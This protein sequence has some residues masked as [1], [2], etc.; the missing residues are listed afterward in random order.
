MT[1]VH[2]VPLVYRN[3]ATLSF[4]EYIRDTVLAIGA[5]KESVN[6]IFSSPQAIKELHGL[7]V[8]SDK[9]LIDKAKSLYAQ[10]FLPGP[11]LTEFWPVIQSKISNGMKW[12]NLPQKAIVQETANIKCLSLLTWVR[13]ALMEAA[14]IA[15]FG[16]RLLELRPDL[17]ETFTKFDN[18]SWKMNYQMPPAT[19]PEFYKNKAEIIAVLKQYFELSPSERQGQMWFVNSLEAQMRQLQMPLDDIACFFLMP[20]W[21]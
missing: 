19:C 6:K 15:V 20:V 21:V 3:T 9:A 18:E 5:S 13:E 1:S 4:D 17:M 8:A 11:H 12:S 10:Q 16:P 14:T 7:D 2:D